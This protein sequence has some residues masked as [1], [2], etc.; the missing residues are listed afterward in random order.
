MGNLFRSLATFGL[1]AVYAV[2]ASRTYIAAMNPVISGACKLGV[3]TADVIIQPASCTGG[4]A[5]QTC[6]HLG[7]A[8]CQKMLTAM[9]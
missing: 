5:F 2:V 1:G 4:A 8:V 6:C 7:G 9:V 3:Y